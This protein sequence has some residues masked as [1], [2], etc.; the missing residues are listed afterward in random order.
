MGPSSN[1]LAERLAFYAARGI[2]SSKKEAPTFYS[3]NPLIDP[4]MTALQ[5]RCWQ[6]E[7]RRINL[8]DKV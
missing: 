6:A 4:P 2:E 5:A 8:G 7:L 3:I 1:T